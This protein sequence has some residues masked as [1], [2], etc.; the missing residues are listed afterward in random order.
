VKRAVTMATVHGGSS[1]AEVPSDLGQRRL[2]VVAKDPRAGKIS[3][4]RMVTGQSWSTSVRI[5]S[6][7]VS[8]RRPKASQRGG[9]AEEE[10]ALRHGWEEVQLVEHDA[11]EGWEHEWST[12]MRIARGRKEG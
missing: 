11:G 3:V 7:L 12:I 2:E 1:A 6:L 5:W 8:S 4:Y 10:Q 9:E